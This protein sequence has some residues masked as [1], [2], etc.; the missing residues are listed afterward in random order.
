MGGLFPPS[1]SSGFSRYG[2]LIFPVSW[3]EESPAC[4]FPA[5]GGE[6]QFEEQAPG[7]G[8]AKVPSFLNFYIFIGV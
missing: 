5:L 2:P 3:I 1:S 8:W 6:A 7:A 4:F